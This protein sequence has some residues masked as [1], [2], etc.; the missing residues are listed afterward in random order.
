MKRRESRCIEISKLINDPTTEWVGI[1]NDTKISDENNLWQLQPPD[2][3]ESVIHIFT[4]NE[5][6]KVLVQLITAVLGRRKKK[7][8]ID[9]RN[10]Q[11]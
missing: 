8:W 7:L 5:I 4:D 3:I 6:I 2:D 10:N 9:N 1:K 11:A